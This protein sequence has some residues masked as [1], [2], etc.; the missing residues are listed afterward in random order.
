[1]YVPS[2]C[3]STEQM[4]RKFDVI[5]A[6]S[7]GSKDLVGK[8]AQSNSDFFGSFGTFCGLIRPVKGLN[9]RYLG[10][11][12]QSPG[13]RKKISSL[14]SGIGINNL[15]KGDIELIVLPLPPLSEQHRIVTKIE[16]LFTQLDAGVA[17]L[18][19]VQAQLKRY[20]Q[21]VL[22][23]AFGGRLTQEWRD[24]ERAFNKQ[25]IPKHEILCKNFKKNS[26]H[27]ILDL[28][29]FPKFP[30]EWTL[31]ILCNVAKVI[32]PQPSHRTPEEFEGGIAYIGMADV[33]SKGYIEFDK[34]RKISKDVLLEHKERYQLKDGD[35]I[36][37]KVGT[38][39]NPV[40]LV[41]PYNYTLSANIVLIQ[42]DEA[43][44]NST[45]SFYYMSSQIMTDLLNKGKL[46]TS[47]PAFGIKKFRVLPI[48]LPT[49]EEQNS[50]VDAID[51]YFSIIDEI[52]NTIET[53]LRQ[54]ES[55]RKSILKLAFEGKLVPQDPNDEP[56]SILLE[57]IKAEKAVTSTNL[58][59]RK[60][61]KNPIES[62]SNS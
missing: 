16:E 11:F 3:V 20:R 36:V 12:F 47:Q 52:E 61:V 50:I 25:Q 59:K 32:D 15:R 38:I 40:K 42:P 7:S 17:S 58:N 43:Y 30:D 31:T 21:A 2:S 55:L 56:A 22:K 45:F 1:V 54:A 23:A 53:S 44:L 60:S 34:A 4:I 29:N 14:S 6:M 49:M 5:V 13:Y 9:E 35:F 28:S 39:G 10:F 46:A 51:R 8:S 19:K 48:P 18:K 57:R 33:T 62:G 27:P 24:S 37:G 41:P 26:Q